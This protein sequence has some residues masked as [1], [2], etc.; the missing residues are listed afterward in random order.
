M[1]KAEIEDLL[2]SDLNRAADAYQR[3]PKFCRENI[4]AKSAWTKAL[5]E[6]TDFVLYGAV[7]VRLKIRR[8]P[9]RHRR[10]FALDK[11]RH[12][13]GPGI[14]EI[15]WAADSVFESVHLSD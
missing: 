7:P 12:D 6:F 4:H 3:A 1:G 8:L 13:I 11:V 2:R 10:L 5:R 14:K 15:H 9:P